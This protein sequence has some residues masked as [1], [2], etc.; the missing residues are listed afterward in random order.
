MVGGA[1]H[2]LLLHALDDP[3]GAV[4]ADLQMA[5]HKAGRGLAL[6]GDERDGLVVELVAAAGIVVV[7]AEAEAA[8]FGG[9]LGD[10]VDVVGPG[11]RFERR[12]D[13][14][15]LLVRD[16]GTVH[17]RHPAAAGHVEHVAA[18]EELFGTAF[19]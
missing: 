6:A 14:L 3:R 1:D 4:V 12:D 15:D 16:E 5:L 8:A 10:L 17:P 7:A 2:A 18:A 13:A 11:A 19:S 9:I